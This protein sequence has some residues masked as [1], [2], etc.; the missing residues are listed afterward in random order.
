[1]NSRYMWFMLFASSMT[2]EGVA[3]ELNTSTGAVALAVVAVTVACCGSSYY[4]WKQR[5]ALLEA[6]QPESI[7]SKTERPD[8]LT[9]TEEA[10]YSWIWQSVMCFFRRP[11][12]DFR[13]L[14]ANLSTVNIGKD[15]DGN[16]TGVYAPVI[17]V[18]VVIAGIAGIAWGYRQSSHRQ[19]RS[20]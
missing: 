11:F 18:S 5:A 4:D 1:M 7:G 8:W 12:A 13:S 17:P 15:K 6:R 16:V 3:V 20:W 14:C 9:E 19:P 2:T 10:G